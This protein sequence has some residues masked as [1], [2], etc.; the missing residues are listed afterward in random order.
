MQNQ[1]ITVIYQDECYPVIYSK[2]YDSSDKFRQMIKPYIENGTDIQKLQ[3]KIIYDKFSSRNVK[4]FLK[5]LQSQKNDVH[6]HEIAEICELAKMFQANQLYNKGMAFVRNRVDPNFCI[7]NDYNE[8][9]GEKYLEIAY[10]KDLFSPHAKSM[11]DISL[12]G[13]MI[14][15]NSNI[16]NS[17]SKSQ[18]KFPTTDNLHSVCYKIQ[19]FNPVMKCCRFFFSKEG[20]ILYTAKHKAKDIF[21]SEGNDIHIHDNKFK[22][23]QNSEGYNIVN[24]DDQEFKIT[25]IPT[26][27]KKQYSLETSFV[28]EGKKLYWS[29]KESD[30][31]LNGEFNHVPIP[32]K[33]NIVLKNPAGS[34]TF[35]FRKMGNDVYEAE[36][37]SSLNPLVIFSISLSQI[38]GPASF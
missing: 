2:L 32:S 15:P 16:E 34:P 21:I 29:P 11:N 3:L 14:Y 31:N 28:H 5:I 17:M 27:T 38:V 10:V 33:K 23:S 36:C 4:N 9:N 26:G 35:I 1:T 6:A 13:K 18:V 30:A 12:N 37:L 22:I 7:T 25:Y 8:E 24:T 19:I 20:R